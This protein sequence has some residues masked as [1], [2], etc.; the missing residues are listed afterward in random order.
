MG[1]PFAWTKTP[2]TRNPAP[3]DP[4]R[5]KYPTVDPDY[6]PPVQPS[7]PVA[8]EPPAQQPAQDPRLAPYQAPSNSD[9]PTLPAE[10]PPPA[11]IEPAPTYSNAKTLDEVGAPPVMIDRD[12]RGR[13]EGAVGGANAGERDSAMLEAVDQYKPKAEGKLKRWAR[14]AAGFGGIFGGAFARNPQAVAMGAEGVGR[15]LTNPEFIDQDW[16]AGEQA[17]LSKRVNDS[18][19]QQRTAATIANLEAQPGIKRR[20]EARLERGVDIRGQ[21]VSD[22]KINDGLSRYSALKEYDP[23]S[24]KFASLK[25]LFEEN[26]GLR[27]LPA[28]SDDKFDVR[29]VNGE[30]E[31]IPKKP[32]DVVTVKKDGEALVDPSHRA[33]QTVTLPNGT[34]LENLTPR[35]KAAWEGKVYESEEDRNSRESIAAAS[36]AGQNRRKL[37]GG[38]GRAGAI[39][40]S[41]RGAVSSLSK[42]RSMNAAV[43]KARAYY[44]N[45]DGP[46]G[47]DHPAVKALIES[48][49]GFEADM[50]RMYGDYIQYDEKGKPRGLRDDAVKPADGKYSEQEVR[51]RWQAT[52]AN[53]RAYKTVEEAISAARKTGLIR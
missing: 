6:I 30:Y 36:Q 9:L 10:A 16:K 7:A 28:K 25:K 11:A 3:D 13:P 42:Y 23:T 39:N 4:S 31:W 51:D 41:V 8:Q 12:K 52:P 20:T 32:G 29:M 40:P 27:D 37:M 21:R 34:V 53:K 24:P 44:G 48:R 26:Y 45:I 2:V 15:G 14:V 22:Q 47:N 43:E 33:D 5:P 18:L 35:E 17:T 46:A 1:L 50:K 49:D 38:P 19:N